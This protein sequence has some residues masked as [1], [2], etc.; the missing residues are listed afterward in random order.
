MLQDKFDE[1]DEKEEDCEAS[2][3]RSDSHEDD[4]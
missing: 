3:A 2:E 4:V 1:E